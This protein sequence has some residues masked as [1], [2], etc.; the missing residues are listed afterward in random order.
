MTRL[1]TGD[2]TTFIVTRVHREQAV[3]VGSATLFARYNGVRSDSVQFF[4]P[5]SCRDEELFREL[6]DVSDLA[7][8]LILS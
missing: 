6:L 8:A 3:A 2:T 1:G 4:L 5:A 7:L